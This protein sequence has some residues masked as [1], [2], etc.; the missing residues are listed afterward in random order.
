[1]T[2]LITIQELKKS[3]RRTD[4]LRGVDLAI[5]AGRVTA[6]LGPNGSGKT[7][8]IKCAMNLIERDA[9]QV[10]VLGVDATK[11]KPAHWRQIGYVSENQQLPDWLT[12]TQLL[13]YVRPMYGECWDGDFEKKLLAEFD[14]PMSD[15]AQVALTRS[16]DEGGA[17]VLAGLSSQ[18]GGARRTLQRTRRPGAG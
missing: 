9:G 7:T 8:T 1:M 5:P 18:A 6:F 12:V 10:E 16:A 4:A 14:L 15:E 17:L 2:D 13:D 11:M 3:F